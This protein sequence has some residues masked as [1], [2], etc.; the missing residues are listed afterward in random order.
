MLVITLMDSLVYV[1]LLLIDDG[2]LYGLWVDG[3]SADFACGRPVCPCFCV[4]FMRSCL[5][6][7]NAL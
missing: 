2:N 6:I 7:C 1:L 3:C 5:G 4:R